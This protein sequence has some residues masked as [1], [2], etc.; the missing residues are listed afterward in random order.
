MLAEINH[1]FHLKNSG[2]N[3]GTS[4]QLVAF[5]RNQAHEQGV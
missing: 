3:L 5:A 1:T 4:L 2:K